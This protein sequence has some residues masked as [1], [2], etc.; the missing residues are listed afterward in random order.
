MISNTQNLPAVERTLRRY[1]SYSISIGGIIKSMTAVTRAMSENAMDNL[2]PTTDGD[3]RQVMLAANRHDNI[4]IT[5]VVERYR[6]TH[7]VP[8]SVSVIQRNL[9]YY[10]P[11]LMVHTE[12]DGFNRNYLFIAPGPVDELQLWGDVL[13]D[14]GQY[15]SNWVLVADITAV[16]ADDQPNYEI[17]DQCGGPI[18]TLDH[19]QAAIFGECRR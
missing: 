10:G 7:T 12:V 14:D 11:E 18:R 5:D 1:S 13:T 3:S 19:E 9:R 6:D 16:L 4:I 15:R 8:E 2:H 17:C